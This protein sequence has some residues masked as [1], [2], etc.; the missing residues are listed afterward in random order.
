MPPVPNWPGAK[1]VERFAVV[2]GYVQTLLQHDLEQATSE[3]VYLGQAF[4]WLG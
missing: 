2:W 4:Q 3:L 1:W